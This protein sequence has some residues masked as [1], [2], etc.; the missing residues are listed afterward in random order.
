MTTISINNLSMFGGLTWAVSSPATGTTPRFEYLVAAGGGGGGNATG[1]T[2]GVGGGGGAGGLEIGTCS[3]IVPGKTYTVICGP[4]GAAGTSG[5][6]GS[7]GN[8][9][10][11]SV[12]STGA[13]GPWFNIVM[14]GGGGGA[15]WLTNATDGRI[16]RGSGGGGANATSLPALG[17]GGGGNGAAAIYTNSLYYA[18]GGGAWGTN[19]T[20]S[21]GAASGT[22]IVWPVSQYDAANGGGG[23][24][25]DYVLSGNP[26]S[27]SVGEHGPG[28]ASGGGGGISSASGQAGSGGAVVIRWPN[29]Y[30]TISQ[31]TGS[32]IYGNQDGYHVY[33]WTASGSFRI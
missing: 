15:G 2:N 28:Y 4:G 23:G 17:T 9:S 25:N 18:G 21:N 10:S 26:I 33:I 19:A 30:N 14:G 20:G 8:D 27:A 1:Y 22:Q 11:I 3:Y 5:G 32:P 6:T 24:M 16:P 13:P 7:Q 29:T 31:V 12:D